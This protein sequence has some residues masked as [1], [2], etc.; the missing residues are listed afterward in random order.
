MHPLNIRKQTELLSSDQLYVGLW[1]CHFLLPQISNPPSVLSGSE[2]V[3]TGHHCYARREAARVQRGSPDCTSGA[4]SAWPTCRMKQE[5]SVLPIL[6]GLIKTHPT[7][8]TPWP[9]VMTTEPHI[10]CVEEREIPISKGNTSLILIKYTGLC[11]LF[12]SPH[13]VYA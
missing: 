9:H 11:P 4:N 8:H 3:N 10:L 7:A 6:S 2:S 5:A 1:C 12:S 13:C